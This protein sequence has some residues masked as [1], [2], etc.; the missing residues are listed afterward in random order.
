MTLPI[1]IDHWYLVVLAFLVCIIGPARLSR[2]IAYDTW[3]PAAWW[4]STWSR[5]MNDGPWSKLF[6][7][8][9]CL[10]P[11]VVG[12]AMLWF[13]AGQYVPWIMVAWWVLWG[14]LALAY[15]ASIVIAYD[16]PE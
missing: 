12:A 14:W 16:E 1:D 5:W 10:T 2:I 3:P 11:W 15:I 9:W 6:T 13:W 4:R 8:T 7:C